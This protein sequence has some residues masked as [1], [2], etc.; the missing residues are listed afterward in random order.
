MPVWSPGGEWIFN[1]DGGP[2]LISPDG[3]IGA[4]SAAVM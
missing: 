2:Q 4:V 1:D 3:K